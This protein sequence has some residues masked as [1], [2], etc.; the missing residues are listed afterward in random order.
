MIEIGLHNTL[1]V[2][3]TTS[4][5]LYLSDGESAEVLLPKKYVPEN[6]EV[7]DMLR[8][9]CYLDHEERPIATTLEPLI[10]RGRFGVLAVAEISRFGAFMDWGLEK[11][12][13]V[14]FRE[15]PAPMEEGHSYPVYCYLD[16]KSGRLVASGRLERFLSNDNMG[17]KAGEEV[18]LMAYR[19][20]DLGVEVVVNDAH[21][22]LVFQD[23]IFRSLQPGDRLSGYVKAIR[24]DKKLDIVLEPL[25]HHGLEPAAQRILEALQ[26]AG[27]FL[28]LHDRTDPEQIQQQLQM[29]KKRF[30]KGV[31]VLYKARKIEM[32]QDG[33]RLL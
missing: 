33:I 21:K 20:T 31:G 23:Q 10:E 27:G 11:H 28:P 25:G 1:L 13:L 4:V 19:Q 5:G 29:S 26:E 8:V 7:G 24:P 12:L 18:S 30:K 14:P 2:S 3:R 15:Q 22:G 6:C 17:L 16:Q 9:F 32:A